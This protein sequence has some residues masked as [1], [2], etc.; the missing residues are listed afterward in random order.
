MHYLSAQYI[1]CL[2]NSTPMQLKVCDITEQSLLNAIW[3]KYYDVYRL[4][5]IKSLFFELLTFIYEV[6]S[7]YES[8][9]SNWSST[10]APTIAQRF[11]L[12][13]YCILLDSLNYKLHGKNNLFLNR[14]SFQ[15]ILRVIML[16]HQ[17]AQYNYNHECRFLL[18]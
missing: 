10:T 6:K 3:I 13:L 8:F 16:R 11:S 4:W 15:I 7:N 9:H 1:P 18:N 12:I 17:I 2:Y 5:W 14:E